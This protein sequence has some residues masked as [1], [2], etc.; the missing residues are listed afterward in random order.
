[1][2]PPSNQP[3]PDTGYSVFERGGYRFAADGVHPVLINEPAMAQ[4]TG[5]PPLPPARRT[6]MAANA[7]KIRVICGGL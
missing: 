7:S 4:P 1:M 6:S 5:D 2:L 3:R